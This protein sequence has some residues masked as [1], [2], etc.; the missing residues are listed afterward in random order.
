[1]PTAYKLPGAGPVIEEY[2]QL[3][4]VTGI[5]KDRI[6]TR[7]S[8]RFGDLVRAEFVTEPGVRGI[9][10]VVLRTSDPENLP[11][12]WAYDKR[13]KAVVPDPKSK[14][15]REAA[16]GFKERLRPPERQEGDVITDTGLPAAF[17]QYGTALIPQWQAFDDTLWVLIPSI[18]ETP[19]PEG[20]WEEISITDYSEAVEDCIRRGGRIIQGR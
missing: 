20:G 4:P 19:G 8:H 1:M 3:L 12:G 18:T 15:T 6:A 7:V 17:I 9:R 5:Y 13:A 16:R 10:D 11:E 2:L 14:D